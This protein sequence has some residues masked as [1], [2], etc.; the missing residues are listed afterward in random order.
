MTE[1]SSTR[2]IPRAQL[3]PELKISDLAASLTFW[4]DALGF[5]V[6]YG[7]PEDGFAYLDRDGAQIMLDQ[8]GL[9]A[10]DRRGIWET[11]ALERPFGRGIN[12]EVHVTDLADIETHLDAAGISIYFGPETRWYRVG[13]REV[14]VRQVLV[15]DPDGYLV[16]LQQNIGERACSHAE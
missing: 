11:G 15:Q 13:D 7:R 12:F 10:P 4:C 6:L 9:G 2:S 1:T 8:R 16:R 3:V 5:R 14:G